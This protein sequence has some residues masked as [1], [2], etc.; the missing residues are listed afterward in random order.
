[1]LRNSVILVAG[2]GH[3]LCDKS[4][5]EAMSRIVTRSGCGYRIWKY[6]KGTIL[7]PTLGA[8]SSLG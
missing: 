4:R 6:G 5:V 1:M 2:S 3:A 7:V 8:F